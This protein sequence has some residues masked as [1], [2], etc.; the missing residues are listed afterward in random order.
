MAPVNKYFVPPGW[1][2]ISIFFIE[3]FTIGFP[4]ITVF[5]T[6][7][8]R[9]E[10]LDAI[11][12]WE[13]RQ[14][15]EASSDSTI[16]V[17]DSYSKNTEAYSSTLKMDDNGPGS[18]HSLE[19]HKSD[20]L[21]MAAL[22]N[23][24]RLNAE[25]LLQFAALKDFSGENVSFL[26]HVAEWQR[27]WFVSIGSTQQQRHQQFIVAVCIYTSFVSLEFSEF[28]INIGSREMK[29]LNDVFSAAA[30]ALMR[31]TSMSSTS[32]SVTPFDCAPPDSSSTVDL[33]TGINLDTLGRAN[34]N[35]AT[36]RMTELGHDEALADVDIPAAFNPEIFENAVREIKYLVLTNTWPKFV[37]AGYA[38]SN[39][40]QEE[41]SNHW[42]IK[43]LTFCGV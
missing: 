24:L 21:T 33:K 27:G 17:S 42:W 7:Q 40:E 43:R 25:P 2:A 13:K 29:H 31:R 34:L 35:S 11:A 22:E 20:M 18:R 8:L 26:T 14:K 10:T 9:Q 38:S 37:N 12:S 4:I 16:A 19:S 3:V 41:P 32:D 39:V 36:P 15:F 5:R 28:P 30:A 6:N 1:F 23:A